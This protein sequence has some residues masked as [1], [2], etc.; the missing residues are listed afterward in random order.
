MLNLRHNK[1][2][3]FAKG[4]RSNK[5]CILAVVAGCNARRPARR[6]ASTASGGQQRS[7][8]ATASKNANLL[9]RGS[10]ASAT[11]RRGQTAAEH[12]TDR[13]HSCHPIRTS[14]PIGSSI[15][16]EE[17]EDFGA[18]FALVPGGSSTHCFS[19]DV[20]SESPHLL[21]LSHPA[22]SALLQEDEAMEVHGLLL[23]RN[24]TSPQSS[25]T[26]RHRP[27]CAIPR[28]RILASDERNSRNWPRER[29]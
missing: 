28:Y 13:N 22:E 24:L 5:L 7:A 3:F 1:S 10:L 12:G 15:F 9:L 27:C 18:D 14:T 11:T 2:P 25:T 21:L 6:S 16:A 19:F 17:R 23:K 26:V 8:P 4:P 20:P 29:R